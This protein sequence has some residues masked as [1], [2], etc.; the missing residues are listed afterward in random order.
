MKMDL[1]VF[2][3]LNKVEEIYVKM[4]ESRKVLEE[5]F[6]ITEDGEI[7]RI[8]DKLEKQ[9]ELVRNNYEVGIKRTH[10]KRRLTTLVESLRRLGVNEEDITEIKEEFGEK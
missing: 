8:K 5:Q 7:N 4:N 2:G 3:F 6:N 9:K 1:D 10:A